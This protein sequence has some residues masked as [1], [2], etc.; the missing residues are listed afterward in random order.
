MLDRD[1]LD[2]HPKYV[3]PFYLKLIGFSFMQKED[4][5]GPITFLNSLKALRSELS[6]DDILALLNHNWRPS[7]VGAWII[8][9]S[10][11]QEL[12]IELIKYLQNRPV[13]CEHVIINLCLFNTEEGNN[14]I[15]KYLEDQLRSMLNFAQ[16]KEVLQVVRIYDTH[17]ISWAFGAIKYLDSIN[18]TNNFTLLIHSTLWCDLKKE[19]YKQGEANP[20][21]ISLMSLLEELE[22]VDLGFD[23]AMKT[24][25]NVVA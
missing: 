6:N 2:F 4:K 1:H 19:W 24:I 11:I 21:A 18:C 25:K 13:Y 17:S 23:S 22:R 12:K 3:E 9:L 15:V 10:Q 7:K 5:Y 14:A 16:E 20:R 8:G